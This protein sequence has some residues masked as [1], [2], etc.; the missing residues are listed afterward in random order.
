MG[1][2][3]D[4]PFAGKMVVCLPDFSKIAQSAPAQELVEMMKQRG[5]VSLSDLLEGKVEQKGRL[6]IDEIYRLGQAVGM[7]SEKHGDSPLPPKEVWVRLS[8]V[9]KPPLQPVDGRCKLSP[10]LVKDIRNA[11]GSGESIRSLA[12][13]YELSASTVCKIVHRHTWKNLS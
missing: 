3:K 8:D 1:F 11:H 7:Q 12:R 5:M 2:Y 13:S 10:L 9:T 6:D 4:E